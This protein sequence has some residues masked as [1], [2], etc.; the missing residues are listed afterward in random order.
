MNLSKINP[1][2]HY[3]AQY[4]DYLNAAKAAN[5]ISLR[6]SL[7]SR[8]TKITGSHISDS[9]PNQQISKINAAD[10]HDFTGL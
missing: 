7:P 8:S 3:E 5:C 10:L 2:K 6:K 1:S 9:Q 4:K